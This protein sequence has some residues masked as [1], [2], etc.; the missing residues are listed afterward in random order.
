[1]P[2][3]PS[4]SNGNTRAGMIG[5]LL[6]VFVGLSMGEIVRTAL[7]A[8]IGASMSFLVTYGFNRVVKKMKNRK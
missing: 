8:A 7:L 5:G 1:M 4:T 3:E 6:F 2:V